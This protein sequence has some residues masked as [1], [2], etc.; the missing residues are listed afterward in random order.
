MGTPALNV[1]KED[2]AGLTAFLA[3]YPIADAY[4]VYCGRR[5]RREHGVGIVQIKT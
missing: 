4:L 1:R 3:A 2:T 5:V